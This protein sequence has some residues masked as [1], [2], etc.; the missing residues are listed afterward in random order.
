MPNPVAL[1]TAARGLRDQAGAALGQGLRAA[2]ETLG[3]YSV[4]SQVAGALRN[5][6]GATGVGFEVL[7][8]KAAMESGFRS[9]AQASTSSARGLFQFIEQT[10]LGVVQE[11]GAAHGLGEE[12]AAIARQG[13]RLTVSDP[14]LRS[15]ILALRDDPEIA[16][17][18]GAEHLKDTADALAP[19]LGGRKPDAA[20]LYLG[21]FLGVRGASELLRKA[22][23]DP[24]MAASQVLPEAARANPAI[25]RGKDGAALSVQQVMDRLRERV[26][27]TYAQ[28]G[29]AAPSGP[30]ALK[31]P[32]E[33]RA[34]GAAVASAEPFW[35]G[36]GSPA[37]V[38]HRQEQ[39]MLSTLVEVFSR[40]AK[41][42]AARGAED[43]RDLP[44][45][46]VQA[47]REDAAAAARKAYGPGQGEG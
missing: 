17:R 25:F 16:A 5:A 41:A 12:A 23:S 20:E 26:N 34:A 38:A 10:W 47:L 45:G 11:H 4:D 8:A 9:D 37:R 1:P 21:H 24:G 29:L 2:R 31:A 6:A 22:A 39:A 35:W 18:L 19:A 15:R 3:R 30:L 33:E 28:L 32:V 40:M 14:A 13:G 43:P 42:G 46:I 44:A 36:S 27:Q 7:A